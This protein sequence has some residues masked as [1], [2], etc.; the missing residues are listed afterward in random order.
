MRALIL[1]PLMFLGC[2]RDV[3][4]CGNQDPCTGSLM[5]VSGRCLPSADAGTPTV[6]QSERVV[7][8]PVV[9]EPAGK[10][11]R[12]SHR[13][14]WTLGYRVPQSGKQVVEAYVLLRPLSRPLQS[15]IELHADDGADRALFPTRAGA[16]V[17]VD[18]PSLSDASL[19]RVDVRQAVARRTL[20]KEA[21]SPGESSILL[22]LNGDGEGDGITFASNGVD[23]PVLEIYLRHG[24]GN[25]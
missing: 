8:H 22:T 20:S 5:C 18:L 14:S 4:L 3:R 21:V 16:H 11:V 24:A 23:E 12:V 25:E 6:E 13:T 1:L 15:P 17:H 19:V 2:A 9:S 10:E 7:L